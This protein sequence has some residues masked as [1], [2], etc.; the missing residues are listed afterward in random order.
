MR[1]SAREQCERVFLVEILA[2]SGSL[3][4]PSRKKVGSKDKKQKKAGEYY[5]E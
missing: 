5:T 1:S 2:A 4:E 3:R